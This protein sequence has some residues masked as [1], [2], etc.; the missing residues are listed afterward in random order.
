MREVTEALE[1]QIAYTKAVKQ[2]TYFTHDKNLHTISYEYPT[3]SELDAF[4]RDNMKAIAEIDRWLAFINYAIPITY[5]AM[6]LLAAYY[7]MA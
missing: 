4:E 7:F 2:I 3:V 1:K 5:T 6:L